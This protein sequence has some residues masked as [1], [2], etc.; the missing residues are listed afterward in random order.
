[1]SGP[2]A[3]GPAMSGPAAS[4]PAASGPA[5]SGPAASGT[6]MSG[7][8][9]SGD[10]YC[11]RGRLG[12][13][14]NGMPIEVDPR[15]MVGS[16]ILRFGV[17]EPE[18][19]GF[20]YCWLRPGMTFV[21]AGAHVGHHTL[22]ASELVGA[23]G[24]VIAFEPHPLLGPV[25]RRNIERAGCA[26]ATLSAM[27]L[28]RASGAADLILHPCDNFG[29]SSLQGDSQAGHRPR[30]RVEVTTLDDYLE[31]AGAP[32]VDVLKLDV[33]GAELDVIDGASRTLAANPDILL[34]VEF[35]RENARRF[36]RDVEDLESRL[37]QL[38]FLL[39]TVTPS[40]PRR[41]EQ[42]GELAANVVAVRRLVT[43][44]NGLPESVAAQTLV[45]LARPGSAGGG[46]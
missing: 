18:T 22:L 7:T 8:A 45:S 21:D 20:F 16:H 35:L 26:N 6:A 19:A 25:L 30:A 40:G 15:D 43:L 12:R 46:R 13:L 5:A 1:M 38:G 27:A 32:M 4:G 14:V 36:G 29:A 2:A 23:E 31:R 41:Y 42:A 33:E 37:R 17:W 34:V 3:S 11:W 28:G 24:R 39:F 44:L 9:A 10:D